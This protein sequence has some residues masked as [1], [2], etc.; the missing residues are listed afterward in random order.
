MTV[1]LAVP[2]GVKQNLFFGTFDDITEFLRHYES[3]S[4]EECAKCCNT[5]ER[6]FWSGGDMERGN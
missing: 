5:N 1:S 2:L 6:K 3:S 4:R